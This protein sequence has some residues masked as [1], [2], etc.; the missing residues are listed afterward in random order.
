MVKIVE[1]EGD[2]YNTNI[3]LSATVAITVVGRDMSG[4]EILNK[5]NGIN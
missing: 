4:R 1:M 3:S 5:R 2:K